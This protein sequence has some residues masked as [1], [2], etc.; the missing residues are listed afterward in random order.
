MRLD[1]S[2]YCITQ[3]LVDALYQLR[4]PEEICV[5]WINAICIYSGA[6]NRIPQKFEVF[7]LRLE[8]PNRDFSVWST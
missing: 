7:V 8:E 5:L 2:V 3:T 4:S 6:S 1:R